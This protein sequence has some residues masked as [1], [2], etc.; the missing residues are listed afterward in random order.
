M[1][2]AHVSPHLQDSTHSV[3]TLSYASPFKTSPPKPRGPAPFNAE[4]PRTWNHEQTVKWLTDEYTSRAIARRAYQHKVRE[5]EATR[6]GQTV[7]P[8]DPNA[9]LVLAVDVNKLC[10]EGMTAKHFGAMYTVQ[11]VQRCMQFGNIQGDVTPEVVK[12]TSAEIMGSLSFLIL[13]AK[14][15]ARTNIMKTRK[16]VALDIYG[17]FLPYG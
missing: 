10:P 12:V 5:E 3:S 9:P 13:R 11:F 1:I 15:K 17:E 4:D 16:H 14:T 7:P 8:L 2:I 6:S